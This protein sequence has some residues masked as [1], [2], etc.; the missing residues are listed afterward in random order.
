MKSVWFVTF[1]S[2]SDNEFGGGNFDEYKISVASTEEKARSFAVDHMK[3]HHYYDWFEGEDDFTFQAERNYEPGLA[4]EIR[5]E[6]REIDEQIVEERSLGRSVPKV[7]T[8][9]ERKRKH[10]RNKKE[11]E[12]ANKRIKKYFEKKE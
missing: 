4:A 3:A 6:E 2:F 5:I 8:K 7:K 11:K 9:N 10:E 1:E 12:E